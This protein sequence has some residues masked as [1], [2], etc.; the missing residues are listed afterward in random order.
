MSPEPRPLP[1]RDANDSGAGL[2]VLV[3]LTLAIFG[4][5]TCVTMLGLLLV[6]HLP[7]AAI[8]VVAQALCSAP[9]VD[10]AHGFVYTRR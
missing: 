6:D 1:E 3:L 9:H 5:A 8:F 2:G 4:F 10:R 7:K